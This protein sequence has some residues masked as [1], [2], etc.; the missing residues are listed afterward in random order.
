VLAAIILLILIGI[1]LLVLEILVIPGFVAGIVGV[2][3]MAGGVIWMYAEYGPVAGNWTAAGTVIG[4]I[5]AVAYSLK[6]RAWRRFGLQGTLEGKAVSV[7]KM[8]IHVG[9]EGVA[10]SA[11][12]PSG[13][14]YI[15]S[16]RVEAQTNGEMVSRDSKVIVQKVL[17]NK[18]IVKAAG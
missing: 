18:I 16:K 5:A 1:V 4:A 11:L 12:R 3:M 17:T 6:S 14:V 15:G 9:D 8:D 7:D 13:T 2:G 10:M